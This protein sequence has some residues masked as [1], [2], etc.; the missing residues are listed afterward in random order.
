MLNNISYL[1]S[2]SFA[3]TQNI[4][5]HPNMIVIYFFFKY[6]F[7][8]FYFNF[9]FTITIHKNYENFFWKLNRNFN[10]IFGKTNWIHFFPSF[11]SF[12]RPI[13]RTFNMH[14]SFEFIEL[15]NDFIN[16]LLFS[17][18]LSTSSFAF[19]PNGRLIKIT[20]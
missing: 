13:R 3:D 6:S 16:N 17:C 19:K 2:V 8:L 18:F 15:L 7:R 4:S 14:F 9:R 10:S 5:R 11:I 12:R 20:K 1:F